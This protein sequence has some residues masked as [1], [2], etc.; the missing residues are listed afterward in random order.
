MS[1]EEES[2]APISTDLA[3]LTPLHDFVL[4]QEI[5]PEEAIIK[6]PVHMTGDYRWVSDRPKG[7][8]RG[9]VVAVGKGDRLFYMT[10]PK[11][12][13]PNGDTHGPLCE[14]AETAKRFVCRNCGAT[15]EHFEQH[16]RAVVT[17]CEMYVKVGDEV[18]YPRV[19]ANDVTINGD[20]Y[21]FLH[22]EQH[23]LALIEQEAA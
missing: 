3:A 15:L 5:P 17:R 19:P 8:R 6:S 20:E 1:W 7:L 12:R 21:T 14:R 22:C 9:R 13:R 23:V 4:V 11:C 10:C 2:F 18:I 16:G